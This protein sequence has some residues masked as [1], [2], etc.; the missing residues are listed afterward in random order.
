MREEWKDVKGFEG[1]YQ[2]SNF[3]R[4]KS[5]RKYKDGYILSQTNRNGWYF[6]VNL[7]DS[8]G[9]RKTKRI[10]VLVAEAFIGDI[11]AGWHVH[12]KD[13]N[14]QN[15]NVGNL[16]IIHPKQHR[17]ETLKQNPKIESGMVN[18]NKFIRP[19]HIRQYDL[20]GHFIAEYANGTI[21]S[22][23]TGICQRNIL[24][25]CNRE[26][27]MKGKTRKQAGGYVWKYAEEVVDCS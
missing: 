12:H 7:F 19:K 23:L 26:E 21:A 25:V 11:P 5:F 8:F 16:E 24:Q 15:N 1:L 27:Y 18:Y 17:N 2:I 6:T 9:D 4:L 14:K 10:H 22:I 20:D 3:G 13:G